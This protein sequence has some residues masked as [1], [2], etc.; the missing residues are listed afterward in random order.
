MGEGGWRCG[1]S[2]GVCLFNEDR[3]LEKEMVYMYFD[4]QNADMGDGVCQG[5]L[6]LVETFGTFKENEKQMVQVSMR[7]I[8][9]I[10]LRTGIIG[11]PL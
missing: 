6:N 5:K 2:A 10:R 11:E 8:G 7:E 4:I 9:L 3:D 1:G